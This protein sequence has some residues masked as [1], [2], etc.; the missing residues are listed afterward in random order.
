MSD[1]IELEDLDD[2]DFVD[3]T[4]PMNRAL[5]LNGR[6]GDGDNLITQAI[7]GMTEAQHEVL[8]CLILTQWHGTFQEAA[9]AARI[10]GGDEN[11]SQA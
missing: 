5:Y 10:L 2:E 3:M 8:K 7:K 4:E 11:A 1:S 6:G 9:D